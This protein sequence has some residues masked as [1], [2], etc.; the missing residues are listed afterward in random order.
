MNARF[1]R[2]CPVPVLAFA[3]SA[4]GPRATP[5]EEVLVSNAS[6]PAPTAAATDTL[7]PTDV[8]GPAVTPTIEPSAPMP[9]LVYVD[10]DPNTGMVG[11]YLVDAGGKSVQLSDK[12]DPVLSPDRS[13]LLY[14]GGGD[15]WLLDLASGKTRNITRTKDRVENYYQWW[16]AHPDLIV[17][18]YQPADDVEPVAGY[19]ATIKPD[20]TNYLL[21]DEE[22]RSFS[23]AALSPDGQSIAYDRGGQ[24][25]I[26]NYS[27]GKMPIFPKSAQQGFSIAMNPEWSPSGRQIAWQLFGM[28]TV[29]EGGSAT[30]VLDLDM[31]S[32]SL[33]HRYTIVDGSGAGIYHLAWSPDGKWL[34]VADQSELEAD[35]K[36]SL[37]V[38]RPDG[39]EEYHIGAG[40]RPIWNPDGTV[41]VFSTDDGTYAVKAGE[42]M[43][44][45]VTLP[46]TARVTAWVEIQ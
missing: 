4:C 23:P 1:F 36:V 6:Q 30:A 18:H 7:F 14:S 15:I 37:W 40:D 45:A 29:E 13:Q 41:L 43:P 9:G 17:F 28:P 31:F 11:P 46:K 19:L 39:G 21:L 34:A 2:W 32:V 24:P 33:L 20:G 12:P 26:Y 25:W 27:G 38:M 5:A 44:F 35:G 3:L 10:L 42:W 22:G 8:V 16:P